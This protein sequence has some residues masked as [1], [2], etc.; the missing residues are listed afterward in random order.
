MG[1]YIIKRISTI[2]IV[3]LAISFMTFCG[4]HMTTRDMALQV[5]YSK[6]GGELITEET[7]EAI[8]EEYGFNDPLVVQ[9]GH[10]LLNAL[11]GD[12]GTSYVYEK[13]V[14][15]V[16]MT[17]LPNTLILGCSAV[18]LS[19]IVSIPFGVLCALNH[20]KVIDNIGRILTMA[21]ASFPSYWVG[22]MLVVLFS[23]IFRIFP[24]AGKSGWMSAV[25]PVITL[26]MGMTAFTTRMMRSSL[27]DIMNEDFINTA[28][29][30][31]LTKMQLVGK[32][33]IR[34]AMPSVITVIGIQIGHVIGGSV[35]VETVFAWPGIG[36]LLTNSVMAK[37]L[38]IIEGCVLL[39]ACGYA[40]VNLAVD[41]IYAL[42]NPEVRCKGGL[43]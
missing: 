37:D 8:R 36:S 5:V 16:I 24:V 12:L 11:Q 33:G 9:Y 19:I 30:K 20:N 4:I 2:I 21:F 18:L 22:I 43:A 6:H 34:N 10:W 15:E 23:V 31:G 40:I 38:P 25:L 42:I 35:I 39:T 29:A 1:K 7:K 3:L 26:S 14:M 41:I 32:H 17:K 28:R 27:L 13:S